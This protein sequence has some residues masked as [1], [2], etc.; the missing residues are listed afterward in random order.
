[1]DDG[2]GKGR[3]IGEGMGVVSHERE[4]HVGGVLGTAMLRGKGRSADWTADEVEGCV[5][6][7]EQVTF[8]G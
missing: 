5:R 6:G 8:P 3:W 1:M 7:S 2:G 4:Q